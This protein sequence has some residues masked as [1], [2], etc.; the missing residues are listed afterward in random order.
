MMQR[1]QIAALAVLL[2]GLG[3]V[4]AL[5]GTAGISTGVFSTATPVPTSTPSPTPL[6]EPSADNWTVSST[7]QLTYSADPNINA[8]VVY[9][10]AASVDEIANLTGLTAPAADD[11][12]P[13]ITLLT[14]IHDELVS[15]ADT[16]Q[17]TLAP[18]AF[19]GP[20]IEIVNDIPVAT[21]RLQLSPQ[22]T[23]GGQE[24]PG[25]DL[26]QMFVQHPDGQI[27]FVQYVLRGEPNPT[28]YADFRAWLSA[29]IADIIAQQAS[30]TATPEGTPAPTTEPGAT[31]Q[32]TPEAAATQ[33]VTPEAAA[34]QEVTPEATLEPSATPEIVTPETTEEAAVTPETTEAAEVV[35]TPSA[36]EA[37]TPQQKWLE[38]SPGELMYAANPSAYIQYTAAP[39]D[40]FAASMGIEAI[41]PLPTAED[42]LNAVRAKLETQLEEGQISVEE[43]AFEGPTAEEI[44]GVTFTY[45]HL[46]LQPQTTPDGQARPAQD[47]VM[48]V[49]ITGENRLTAIQFIYQGDP[50]SSIYSDFREWLAQN[51]T[52]L[53]TLEISEGMPPVATPAP[54]IEPVLVPTAEP[55]VEP[56]AT[57][58]GS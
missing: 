43:G 11:P 23:G 53:S 52:L 45:L 28:V 48:G 54:T 29:N 35:I 12:Y 27:T 58:S 13:L 51:I 47:V 17:L 34:T 55:T 42:I 26:V 33:E 57:S 31:E 1:S 4:L 50:D 21:M 49:I 30:P 2:V 38:I 16:S 18:D 41:D 8:Q 10:T 25:L 5:V 7:G 15:Q 36:A 37:G 40:Q 9:Q 6:P 39:L 24:F 32:V 3:V 56:T 14:E 46:T 20:V 44:D 19:T 22:T